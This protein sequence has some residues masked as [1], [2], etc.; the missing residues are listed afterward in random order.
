MVGVAPR[1]ADRGSGVRLG[2]ACGRPIGCGARVG[3]PTEGKAAVDGRTQLVGCFIGTIM[4][5]R[6]KLIGRGCR[7][8]PLAFFHFG[9]K[10]L[11]QTNG[12]ECSLSVFGRFLG[13]L[14]LPNFTKFYQILP[15][16]TKSVQRR[17]SNRPRNGG[18]GRAVYLNRVQSRGLCQ[19]VTVGIAVLEKSKPGAA[20]P[21]PN[22]T[23]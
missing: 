10:P 23:K 4:V 9:V 6:R 17:A 22:W 20:G 16:S 21:R 14:G 3:G 5:Q 12:L 7:N 13:L 19:A 2:P 15:I 8:F 11:L 1:Q 18:S